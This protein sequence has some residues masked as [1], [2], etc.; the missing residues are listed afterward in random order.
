MKMAAQRLTA[1]R[2]SHPHSFNDLICE[3]GRLT[4][5]VRLAG[6]RVEPLILVPFVP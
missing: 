1:T 4:A 6:L 3:H 5:R 2:I